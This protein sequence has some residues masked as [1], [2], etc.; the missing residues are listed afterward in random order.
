MKPHAP[1]KSFL[2]LLIMDIL[3]FYLGATL[4]AKSLYFMAH[5]NE[6]MGLTEVA[7]TYSDFLLVHYIVWA[8]LIGGV[9]IAIG[10][11]T[12]IA[13]LVNLPILFGAV[14]LVHAKDGFF[15]SGFSL[16]I[17]LLIFI[18][19]ILYTIYGSGRFSLDGWIKRQAEF[20]EEDEN[21]IKL[22]E[23]I[24]NKRVKPKKPKLSN[25][26]TK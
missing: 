24:T 8:H 15:S 21:Y 18:G 3:R 26:S 23:Y 6:L 14:F 1:N 25:L 19:L 20:N 13:C 10:I 9:F 16:E 12:R 11:K 7:I 2:H 4:I 5:M 22:Q 17:S